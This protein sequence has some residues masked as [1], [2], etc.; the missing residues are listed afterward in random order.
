MVVFASDRASGRQGSN[1]RRN[2]VNGVRWRERAG[3]ETEG[4]VDS[5]AGRSYAD[6]RFPLLSYSRESFFVDCCVC[7]DV[8]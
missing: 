4:S 2:Q 7:G 1:Q 6:T 5:R 3:R 8:W